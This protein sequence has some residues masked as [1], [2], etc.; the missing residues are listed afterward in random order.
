MEIQKFRK[1]LCANQGEIALR[2]FRASNELGSRTVAIFS[3]EDAT[4]QHRYKADE[5]YLLGQGR[6]PVEAYLGVDEILG[7]AEQAKVDAIHPGYGFLSEDAAFAAACR[8]RGI[9]FIGPRDK[10]IRF[11]GDKVQARAHAEELGIPV[12]PGLGLEVGREDGLHSAE[13]FFRAHG[14]VLVKAAHGGGGRG[15]RVVDRLQDLPSAIS[16][17]SSEAGAAFGNPEVFLEKYLNPCTQPRADLRQR[18]ST[19]CF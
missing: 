18:N 1:I 19:S 12:V 13:E 16:Q 5:A 3:E 8:S 4:H 2:V 6:K 17:A 11:L 9:A 7:I 15:M 10:V 14:T